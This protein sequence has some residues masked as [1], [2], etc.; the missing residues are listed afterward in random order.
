MTKREI[1]EV[2]ARGQMVERLIEG[3]SH[4]ALDFDLYDLSQMIY[5]ALLTQPEERIINLYNSNEMEFFIL[6]IIKKQ[7]FS[8]T[9]PYF[10]QIRKFRS[11]SQPFAPQMG[12]EAIDTGEMNDNRFFT[13]YEKI[14]TN[15]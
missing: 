6:G 5:E 4:Q 7:L 11:L 10:T 15:Q 14:T 8:S 3:V 2:M 1:L 12:F 13:E 9:S